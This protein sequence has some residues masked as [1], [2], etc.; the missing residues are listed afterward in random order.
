M[1]DELGV[2]TIENSFQIGRNHFMIQQRKISSTQADW[3]IW[4][5]LILERKIN[6]VV[7]SSGRYIADGNKVDSMT[8]SRWTIWIN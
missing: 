2:E 8:F 6:G 3:G 7:Q 5:D 1:R 4:A